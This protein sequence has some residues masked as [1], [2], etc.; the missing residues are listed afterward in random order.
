MSFG[1]FVVY[2]ILRIIGI[3]SALIGM[4]GGLIAFGNNRT[5]GVIL[6]VFLFIGG[7]LLVWYGVFKSRT[8]VISYGIDGGRHYKS[9]KFK[10]KGRMK[11][12]N[13]IILAIAII[14]GIL[15]VILL[16]NSFIPLPFISKTVTGKLYFQSTMSDWANENYIISLNIPNG[17]PKNNSVWY[18]SLKTEFIST[19]LKQNFELSELTFSFYHN[20]KTLEGSIS[21]ECYF[22]DINGGVQ[23]ISKSC[24][25][26]TQKNSRFSSGT[27]TFNP[28]IKLLSNERLHFRIGIG[29][30]YWGSSDTPSHITYKGVSRYEEIPVF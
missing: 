4:F 11:R 22:V 10:T 15:I 24:S 27:I 30:W 26:E 5:D 25:V 18:G 2:N 14:A 20:L 19:P 21:I 17:E 6:A 7:I 13:K 8:A 12:R 9:H 23:L 3:I 29:L 1:K 16:V 28:P